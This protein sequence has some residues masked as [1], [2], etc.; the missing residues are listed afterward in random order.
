MHKHNQLSNGNAPDIR[1]WTSH[2]DVNDPVVYDLYDDL[3]A[4]S[5]TAFS[6][7]LNNGVSARTMILTYPTHILMSVQPWIV[8]PP[9]KFSKKNNWRLL[10][11]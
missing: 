6:F 7:R 4:F 8:W 9:V 5:Q 10:G 1:L 3:F 11:H 2:H